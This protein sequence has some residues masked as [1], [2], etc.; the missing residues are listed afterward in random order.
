LYVVRTQVSP[1][2]VKKLQRALP[3]CEIEH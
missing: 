2:G 3:A 1:E